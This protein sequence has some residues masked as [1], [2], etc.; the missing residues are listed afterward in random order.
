MKTTFFTAVL[1]VVVFTS[2][3][4]G[5][6]GSINNTLGSGG[7]FNI[8]YGTDTLLSLIQSNGYLSLNKSLTLPV[9]TNSTLGV[10]FKGANRFLHNYGTENTF[11]GINSGNFTMTGFRNSAFG[12]QSLSSTSTGAYNTALGYQSLFSNTAGDGNIALG[13]ESMYNNKT[14]L[15]NIALGYQS[16]Y[17]NITANNNIAFGT[18]SLYSN[19]GGY[20]NTSVGNY[21]LYSN[22]DGI[23]NTALGYESMLYNNT[24]YYNTAMGYQSLREN[25]TGTRNTGVGYLS[26]G[27]SSGSFNTALGFSSGSSITSGSNLTCIGYNAQPTIGTATNQI[28]LG[29]GFV[30]LL[31]CNVQTITSL[32]DMRDKKN[33]KDLSLGLEFLM[34]VKP[35]LF[36]WDR[37][38][39]YE[40]GKPDGS[41]MKENLTAGFI[42]Q[43]LDEVQILEEAEWLNLVLKSNPDRLEATP[44]N[45]LPIMVKAIQELKQENNALRVELESLKEIK[46]RIAKLELLLDSIDTK[47]AKR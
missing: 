41:K 14:G 28:T 34:K 29:D 38:E 21:S 20:E 23:R 43:E 13:Y 12:F 19:I 3:L 7:S 44:G 27:N 46:G 36:N 18:Q 33:I 6:S 42:A 8:K 26:L 40:D 9:T 17:S 4:Y 35:R 39:W 11:M 15:F 10:I 22:F 16:L 45:L 30:A 32:S 25:V 2:S 31:R 1:F 37:R 24:G 5:Q 47:L